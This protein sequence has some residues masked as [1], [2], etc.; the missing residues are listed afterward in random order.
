MTFLMVRCPH[1]D[2]EQIAVILEN[3]KAARHN[4]LSIICSTY[5]I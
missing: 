3:S 4:N 5:S 1:C 2:S